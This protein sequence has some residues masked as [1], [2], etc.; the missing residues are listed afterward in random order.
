MM[1]PIAIFDNGGA[2]VDRYT[3]LFVESD[4]SE[5]FHCWGSSEHPFHPQ[6]FGQYC[7]EFDSREEAEDFVTNFPDEMI[8]PLDLPEDVYRLFVQLCKSY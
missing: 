6:G 4:D 3:L 2:T 1:L 8:T 5:K 7:G